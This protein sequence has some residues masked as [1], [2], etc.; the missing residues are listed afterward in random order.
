MLSDYHVH[1]RPDGEGSDFAKYMTAENADRYRAAAEEAGITELGASEHIYRFKQALTVWDHPLWKKYAV[2]DIDEYARFVRSADLKLGIEADWVAGRDEQMAELIAG[3]EWDYVLGSVHFLKEAALDMDTYDIWKE[4]L[5]PDEIWRNYFN[6]LADAARSGLYDIM[7]HPDL[8]KIWGKDRPLP[9][10]DLRFF[11][12]PAVE[13][14]AEAD[15]TVE[16]STA[17]LRKPVG[18]IYPAPAFIDM[19]LDAGLKFAL[20]SDAHEPLHVGYGYE[21]ALELLGAHGITELA[22]YENRQ[23][24]MEPIG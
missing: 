9:E 6:T 11:Y 2:D 22:V 23:R 15:V 20:S 5:S 19:C 14:F 7:S 10:G 12:E 21:H 8:V 17:G 16:M 13:A 24:R 3:N 18:E 4:R 1:L